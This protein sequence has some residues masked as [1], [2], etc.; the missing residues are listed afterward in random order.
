MKFVSLALC[1]SFVVVAPTVLAQ[2]KSAASYGWRGNWTGL[3]P[4]AQVPAQWS[5]VST[6]P[7]AG[8]KCAATQPADGS[9]KDA[10]PVLKGMPT[11]WLVIG[12]WTMPDANKDFDREMIPDEA[13]LAPKLGD[14]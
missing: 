2:D 9:D 3:Y 5:N 6:G 12:P 14:T 4:D 11:N 10:V 7:M 8:M 1:L 13:K